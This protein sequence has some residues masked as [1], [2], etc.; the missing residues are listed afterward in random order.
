M[1]LLGE[2]AVRMSKMMYVKALKVF[3]TFSFPP[4]LNRERTE[5]DN[6]QGS[7]G[8]VILLCVIY[9]LAIQILI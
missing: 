1:P 6:S 5:S 4:S 8:S 9:E 7:H 2:A 3:S